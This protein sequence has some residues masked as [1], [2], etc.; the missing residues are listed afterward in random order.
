LFTAPRAGRYKV[1]AGYKS[2]SMRWDSLTVNLTLTDVGTSRTARPG[3]EFALEQN[4]PNPFNPSTVIPF[5]ISRSGFVMLAIYNT[6]GQEVAKLVS[7]QLET[8]YHEVTFR[9]S[10]LVSGVYMYK[11]RAGNFVAT[12]KLLMLK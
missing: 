11:L 2:P 9:G 10:G 1:N 3:A 6:L 8:G 12:K 5:E 7:G 4:Y